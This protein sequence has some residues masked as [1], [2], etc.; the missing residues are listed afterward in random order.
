M[1]STTT[2]CLRRASAFGIAVIKHIEHKTLMRWCIASI[3]V[4]AI[5]QTW[6]TTRANK[7]E[8]KRLKDLYNEDVR[9]VS[10]IQRAD[11]DLAQIK[12]TQ[13]VGVTIS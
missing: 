6:K 8:C 4:S 10:G 7:Q 3:D 9:K 1:A 13:A 2:S 5:K 11:S 12:C